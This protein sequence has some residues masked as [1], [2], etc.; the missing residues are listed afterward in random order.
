[1]S[2]VP[3]HPQLG[4]TLDACAADNIGEFFLA[5][6]TTASQLAV[7]IYGPG[8][9]LTQGIGYTTAKWNRMHPDEPRPDAMARPVLPDGPT[10]LQREIYKDQKA[11]WIIECADQ[12]KLWTAIVSSLSPTLRK[13]TWDAE[14]GHAG[15]TT[16]WFLDYLQDRFGV[17]T[18]ATLQRLKSEIAS[19]FTSEDDF[20]SRCAALRGHLATL[21]L[22]GQPR[23]ETDKLDGF[24]SATSSLTNVT[25]FYTKYCEDVERNVNARTLDAAITYV[26]SQKANFSTSRTAGWAGSAVTR[27]DDFERRVEARALELRALDL[28]AHR[29]KRIKDKTAMKGWC[30]CHGPG[31]SGAVCEFMRRNADFFTPEF[32]EATKTCTIKGVQSFPARVHIK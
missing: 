25:H 32:L 7:T 2:S 15:R 13:D 3:D 31:H 24:H 10:A 6:E 20:E 16:T 4:I 22:L 23:S 27:D 8:G 17:T 18:A 26:I 21:A 1:M 14:R 30:F 9:L 29:S 19:P 5:V 11:D 12:Y 28:T